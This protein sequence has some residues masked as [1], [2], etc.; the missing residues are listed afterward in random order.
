MDKLLERVMA[1]NDII[2]RQNERLL[3]LLLSRK[4]KTF[5]EVTEEVATELNRRLRPARD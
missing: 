5:D 3:R 1:Q 4:D 2:I